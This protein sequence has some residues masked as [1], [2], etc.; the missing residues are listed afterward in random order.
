[1]PYS[2]KRI[3]MGWLFAARKMGQRNLSAAHQPQR[4][5]CEIVCDNYTLSG[6]DSHII[7]LHEA[8]TNNGLPRFCRSNLLLSRADRHPLY[9]HYVKPGDPSRLSLRRHACTCPV[10]PCIKSSTE[11]NA[12][13]R[14][15]ASRGAVRLRPSNEHPALKQSVS[16]LFLEKRIEEKNQPQNSPSGNTIRNAS[17]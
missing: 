10:W 16:C 11:T 7:C 6:K 8:G 13:V 14:L 5:N 2:S 3:R 1:L 4:R 15:V 17:G 9:T 12:A